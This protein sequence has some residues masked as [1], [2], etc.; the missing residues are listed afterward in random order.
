M[1]R[2]KFDR[3]VKQ[4]GGGLDEGPCSILAMC[5]TVI[6]SRD[7]LKEQAGNMHHQQH[8]DMQDYDNGYY[9][10]GRGEQRSASES[11]WWLQGWDAHAAIAQRNSL[12]ARAIMQNLPQI[13]MALEASRRLVILCR[14]RKLN[15]REKQNVEDSSDSIDAALTLVE[16]S[17]GE[18]Q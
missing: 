5:C 2:I 8:N 16:Q 11:T 14:G 10:F 6:S 7:F 3:G 4:E 9:A 1:I 15:Y 12:A 17:Q 18:L 13:R